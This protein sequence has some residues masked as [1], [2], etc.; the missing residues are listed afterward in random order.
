MQFFL[1]R[2]TKFRLSINFHKCIDMSLTLTLWKFIK[3]IINF[4]VSSQ[5]HIS[6][7]RVQLRLRFNFFEK[8]IAHICTHLHTAVW[9]LRPCAY[10]NKN[11]FVFCNWIKLYNFSSGNQQVALFFIIKKIVLFGSAHF[12]IANKLNMIKFIST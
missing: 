7:K 9:E 2:S 1:I 11:Y 12:S 4:A 3:C 8:K 5:T 10:L 6:F